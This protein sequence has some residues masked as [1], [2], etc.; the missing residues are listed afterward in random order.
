[1]IGAHQL[2]DRDGRGDTVRDPSRSG[3][4]GGSHRENRVADDH[5]RAI[6]GVN[7]VSGRYIGHIPGKIRSET[8]RTRL[9]PG[10]LRVSLPTAGAAGAVRRGGGPGWGR[11][12][13]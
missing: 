3:K 4:C 9:S 2:D 13:S 7:G 11:T 1:M 6:P 10:S 12:A 5:L 8:A